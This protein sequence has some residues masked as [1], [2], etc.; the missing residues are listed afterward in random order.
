MS[1]PFIDPER[2]DRWSASSAERVH[3][4]P[5]SQQLIASIPVDQRDTTPT[6][7]AESGTRIHKA[8]EEDCDDSLAMGESEIREQLKVLEHSAANRWMNEVLIPYYGTT[9]GE[10]ADEVV[11]EKRYWVLDGMLE[12]ITSAKMDV[13]YIYKKHALVIDGKTGFKQTTPAH[14]NYQCKVQA[15]AITYEF[16]LVHV[17]V[18]IAAHRFQST[19]TQGDYLIEDIERAH[20]EI[21]FDDWK[22]K[23]PDAQRV[24][25][26]WCNFCP[27]KNHCREAGAYTLLPSTYAP[28]S[29]EKKFTEADAVALVSTLSLADLTMIERRRGISEK[30]FQSVKSRLKKLPPA[31]LAA[32]GF[33]LTEGRPQK[34]IIDLPALIDLLH[35][36]IDQGFLTADEFNS[37]FDFKVGEAEKVILSRK[38]AA[39]A[40]EGRKLTVKDAKGELRMLMG[41]SIDFAATRTDPILK[42]TL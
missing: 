28:L 7:V 24:P 25:G 6:E 11:R 9:E 14:R 40:K 39:A 33:E 1:T 2:E 38:I 20:R 22:S 10:T 34:A 12:K 19:L 27:A 30:I 18:A 21:V 17:R 42:D 4:C 29:P 5:G 32:L 35:Q 16:E 41:S 37:L 36:Q 3:Y 26:A 8:W 23:Q 31:E 15:V 13:A